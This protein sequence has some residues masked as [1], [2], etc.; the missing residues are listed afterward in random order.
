MR[1]GL[2]VA[3]LALVAAAGGGWWWYRSHPAKPVLPPETKPAPFASGTEVSYTGKVRAQQVVTVAAPVEGEVQEYL[4]EVGDEVSEGQLLARIHNSGL[5]STRDRAAEEVERIQARVNS[6]ET[7][8]I[9]GRLDESRSAADS[10]RAQMEFARLEKIYQRQQLLYREGA[11]PRLTYEK[12]QADYERAKTERD[13]LESLA[14]HVAERIASSQKDLDN[15]RKLLDSKTGDLDQAK[16]DLQGTDV[17]SPV[18]GILVGRRGSAG[19]AVN[20]SIPDFLQIAVDLGRLEV[21]FDMPPD[22][23]TRLKPNYA[24]AVVLAEMGGEPLQGAVKSVTGSQVVAVFASP[25]P[26]VRPGVTAQVRIR[27]P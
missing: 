25:N 23:A 22:V 5:L 6:L 12:A 10:Q 27:L 21:V 16:L 20:P 17:N 14:Q 8:L 9:Q 2:V 19:E 4:A 26:A 3:A 13:N 11:T 15:A 18:D 7:G 24:L 1:A